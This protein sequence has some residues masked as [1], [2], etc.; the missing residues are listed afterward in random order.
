MGENW[1]RRGLGWLCRGRG[2]AG[3]RIKRHEPNHRG[4]PIAHRYFVTFDQSSEEVTKRGDGIKVYGP[5]HK[6]LES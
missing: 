1:F 5:S 2:F 3:R 6:A 4:F